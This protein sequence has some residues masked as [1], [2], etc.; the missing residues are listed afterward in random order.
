MKPVWDKFAGDI[1]ADMINAAQKA[2]QM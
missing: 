2:N 1:G